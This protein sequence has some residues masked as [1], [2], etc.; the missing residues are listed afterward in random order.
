MATC[1]GQIFRGRL[2]DI[3]RDNRI[4]DLYERVKALQLTVNELAKA[5]SNPHGES[6]SAT[7][8][9]SN[10]LDNIPQESIQEFFQHIF[11]ERGVDDIPPRRAKMISRGKSN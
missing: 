9:Y 2:A 7:C 11:E 3:Q 5:P 6:S 4:R 10:Q 1:T 8:P